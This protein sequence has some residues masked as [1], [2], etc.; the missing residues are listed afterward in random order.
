[1]SQQKQPLFRSQIEVD[2]NLQAIQVPGQR[3]GNIPRHHPNP[4]LV[5][6]VLLHPP[7]MLS[8]GNRH[9]RIVMRPETPYEGTAAAN[10]T[11]K[12]VRLLTCHPTP[13]P[14]RSLKS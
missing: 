12:W 8:K 5:F 3:I 13:L 2:M 1:M 7:A 11:V 6:N 10:G 4:I 14:P 9:A